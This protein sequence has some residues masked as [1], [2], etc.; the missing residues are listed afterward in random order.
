MFRYAVVNLRKKLCVTLKVGMVIAVP[1]HTH[2]RM[3]SI[4]GH[5][6]LYIGNNQVMDNVGQIRTLDGVLVGLLFDLIQAKMGL[7]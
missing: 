6:C 1:S 2:I 5:A 3:G 7:V 4:Y